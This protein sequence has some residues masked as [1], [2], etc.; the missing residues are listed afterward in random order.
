[1]LKIANALTQVFI[2]YRKYPSFD[3]QKSSRVWAESAFAVRRMNILKSTSHFLEQLDLSKYTLLQ[4]QLG[5][6]S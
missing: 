4:I 2:R 3:I 6:N 5:E 1:M